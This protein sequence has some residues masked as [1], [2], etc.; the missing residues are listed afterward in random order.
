L[1]ILVGLLT[2]TTK[3][4]SDELLRSIN[5][6]FTAEQELYFKSSHHTTK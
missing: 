3:P 6:D 5:V 1:Y 4:A 2:R